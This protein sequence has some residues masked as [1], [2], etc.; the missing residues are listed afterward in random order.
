M[1]NTMNTS[2]E[3]ELFENKPIFGAIMTLA[4]PSILG[5][6]I[7]VIYNMADTFFV[8]LAGSDVM[9]TAVTICMPSFMFISAISNLF[10]I[11]GASVISRALG[12]KQI[13]SAKYASGFAVWGCLA[14]TVLY[15]L[16]AFIFSDIFL[17]ILG[18]SHADVHVNA[19][20][21]LIVTVVICG[22]PTAM[23]TLFS[24]LIRSQGMSF[25]ASLGIAIGG[26]L[27]I[28][29]DPLFMFVILPKGNE[30][31]GAGIATGLANVIA[32][33][34]YIILFIIKRKNLIISVKL[35]K[36]CFK[37]QIPGRVI[38]IGIPACL[39][40]LC[41]NISYAI[42]DNLM[43]LVSI[44]AQT[45]VG[46]A[47][48]INMFAH[49]TVRGMTQGVLPLIGY[50]KTSGNRKRMKRV[51]YMS[52]GISLGIS[53]ICTAVS[54]IFT[55]NLVDIFIHSGTNASEFGTDFL[56]ILCIGAPFSAIAYTVISFFQAAGKAFRSLILALLRKGILDIPL[57]F[58]LS[59]AVPVYGI[60][61]ATPIADLVCAIVAVILFLHYIKHHA[62]DNY[63]PQVNIEEEMIRESN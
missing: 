28:A 22:I 7:L 12:K 25:H 36:N 54:L 37:N 61:W 9:T 10:G 27:N 55:R 62:S 59:N 43:G 58:V 16:F 52:G 31:L 50:N 35:S 63:Q 24:H 53:L 40:T 30:A 38:L 6:L 21:Y 60:V 42:L 45:G 56:R 2:K 19:K 57:M 15:S 23:N 20:W 13:D 3:K 18:G 49:S 26:I 4:L 48:K 14:V 5:Q 1:V 29:L 32:L 34:Y 41:E 44:E 46:V 8:G 17:D 39:M 47:K 11:G 33:I 51:V